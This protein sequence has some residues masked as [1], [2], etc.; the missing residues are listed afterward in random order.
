MGCVVEPVAPEDWPCGSLTTIVD[1]DLRSGAAYDGAVRL[2]FEL[3]TQRLFGDLLHR[4]R[5]GDERV[6]ATLYAVWRW[7]VDEDRE[8]FGERSLDRLLD[9]IDERGRRPE[10]ILLAAEKESDNGFRVPGPTGAC[11]SASLEVR[12]EDE[13]PGWVL[14]SASGIYWSPDLSAPPAVQSEWC[15]A[16]ERFDSEI[17]TVFANVTDDNATGRTA[18]DDALNRSEDE[19]VSRS[20]SVLRGYSWVTVCARELVDRLGGAGAL[21]ESGAFWKVRV[22]DSCAV[23]LQATERLDDFNS[24][25]IERVFTVL[26]PVLPPGPVEPIWGND[27]PRLVHA[28]ASRSR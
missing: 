23:W 11:F 26:A 14:F 1:V 9:K 17:P 6:T 28:D 25:A 5:V 4:H 3:V 21:E 24:T 16:V 27:Y 13:L 10:L 22:F 15:T 2:W 7:G 18:L 8:V 12:C 20:R 19:S